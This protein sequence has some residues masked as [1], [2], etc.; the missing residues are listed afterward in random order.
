MKRA[1]FNKTNIIS[2]KSLLTRDVMKFKI[3]KVNPIISLRTQIKPHIFK[4]KR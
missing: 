3:W 1:K 4:V 2:N